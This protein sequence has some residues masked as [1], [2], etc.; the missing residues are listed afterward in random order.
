M[1]PQGAGT[2]II[3]NSTNIEVATTSRGSRFTPIRGRSSADLNAFRASKN[4]TT[5]T[6]EHYVTAPNLCLNNM[7]RAHG[8]LSRIFQILDLHHLSV[9]LLASSIA[10]ISLALHSKY[11]V[12][13]GVYSSQE[14]G[15]ESL[16]IDDERLK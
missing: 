1:Y 15:K 10:H 5:I 14:T 7:I 9:D 16:T 12:V 3:L 11:P 6:D 4:P 8:F 2:F 13:S